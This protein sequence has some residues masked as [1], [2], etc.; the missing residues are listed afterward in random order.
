MGMRKGL[1]INLRFMVLAT[2]RVVLSFTKIGHVGGEAYGV[3]GQNEF[4]SRRDNVE[5]FMANPWRG[6]GSRPCSSGTQGSPQLHV[7]IWC[8]WPQGG[9]GSHGCVLIQKKVSNRGKRTGQRVEA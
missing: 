6:P 1:R 5:L 9:G 2:E 4:S 8:Y 7:Q 3:K